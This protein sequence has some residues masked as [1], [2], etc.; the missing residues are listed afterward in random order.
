MIKSKTCKKSKR[1]MKM[2]ILIAKKCIKKT[3]RKKKALFQMKK[4]V[5]IVKTD[6]EKVV[7]S[8]SKNCRNIMMEDK[9]CTMS[10]KMIKNITRKIIIKVIGSIKI[11][12]IAIKRIIKI[13]L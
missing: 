8:K 1:E 10:L 5:T 2:I 3:M 6:L 4:E 11:M 13:K 12:I 7:K 9:I